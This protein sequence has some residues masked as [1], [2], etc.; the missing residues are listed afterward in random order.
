MALFNEP[1]RIEAARK[2]AER[3]L[4]EGKDDKG[5]LNLLFTLLASRAPCEVE[6]K[7]CAKLL[8]AMRGRYLNA[9]SDALALLSVGDAPRDPNLKAAEVAAWTQLAVIVLASDAAL[10]IY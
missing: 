1:Q 3:L 4:H 6:R 10:F 8:A 5:R 9:E 7:A 2:L